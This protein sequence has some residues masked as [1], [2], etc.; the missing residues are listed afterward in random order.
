MFI[1][2]AALHCFILQ[3]RPETAVIVPF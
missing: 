1:F 2:T 3:K